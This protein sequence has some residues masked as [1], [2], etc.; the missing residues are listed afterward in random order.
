MEA[1]ASADLDE[2][3][4]EASWARFEQLLEARGLGSP[5]LEELIGGAPLA[6]P[7]GEAAAEDAIAKPLPPEDRGMEHPAERGPEAPIASAPAAAPEAALVSII[8]LCYS[9]R[10]ALVRAAGLRRE[11]TEQ[12]VAGVPSESVRDLIEEVLD[13]VDL[14]LRA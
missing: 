8:D 9:G 1:P 3:G 7:A 4:L 12:L 11:I 10:D 14:G 6:E 13:L 5:S 2:R